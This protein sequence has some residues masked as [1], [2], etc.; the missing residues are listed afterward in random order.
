MRADYLDLNGQRVRVECNWNALV[1]YLE[2]SGQNDM[3]ALANLAQLRPSDVAGLM[4]ACINEGE[5]LDGRESDYTA[6]SIGASASYAAIG[7]FLAIYVRQSTPAK[8]AAE[9]KKKA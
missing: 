9:E 5:R 3:S 2:A 7:E 4:A 8:P 6:E 1:S